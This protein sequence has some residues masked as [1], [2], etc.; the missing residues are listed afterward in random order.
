MM[1]WLFLLLSFIIIT[2][3]ATGILR[4]KLRWKKRDKAREYYKSMSGR[5]RKKVKKKKKVK[6]SYRSSSYINTYTQSI[7]HW[8][9][10]EEREAK[11]C[12][13]GIARHA[14]TCFS[15]RIHWQSYKNHHD[16]RSTERTNA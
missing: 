13:V 10:E 15:I 16:I 14:Q 12:K 1:F 6:Q 4:M 3:S 9:D 8:V 2:H 5:Y 7:C 11:T